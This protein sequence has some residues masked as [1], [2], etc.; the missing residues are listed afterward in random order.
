LHPNPNQDMMTT[1]R[2][3]CLTCNL[4]LIGS[5]SDEVEGDRQ[6]GLAGNRVAQGDSLA[7]LQ[8]FERAPYLFLCDK[9]V[10]GCAL[11]D[12]LHRLA[13]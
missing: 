10:E 12:L 3:M 11:P 7:S 1:H 9:A 6:E 8:S 4:S 2:R 5:R 13:C